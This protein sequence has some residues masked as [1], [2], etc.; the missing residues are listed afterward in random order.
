MHPASRA[1]L[2]RSDGDT[3]ACSGSRAILR[4]SDLNA[5]VANTLRLE[6]QAR[7]RDPGEKADE[8][9]RRPSKLRMVRMCAVGATYCSGEELGPRNPKS[10]ACQLCDLRH[11]TLNGGGASGSLKSVAVTVK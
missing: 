10:A 7:Q 3:T 8:W 6:T 11:V 4:P 5:A 2:R 9:F 1:G